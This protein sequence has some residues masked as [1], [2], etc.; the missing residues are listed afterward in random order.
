M[1]LAVAAA[2][3]AFRTWRRTSGAQRATYLAAQSRRRCRER[4]IRL[5]CLNTANRYKK[6]PSISMMQPPASDYYADLA[7]QLDAGRTR[8]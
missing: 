6:R 2:K 4:L 7:S 8:R 3:R 1:D 5:V